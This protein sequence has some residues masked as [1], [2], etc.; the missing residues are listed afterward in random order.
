MVARDEEC[1]GAGDGVTSAYRRRRRLDQG[2]SQ[3]ALTFVLLLR[4]TR[5]GFDP[6]VHDLH[7]AGSL[8][9]DVP[10]VMRRDDAGGCGAPNVS[11]SGPTYPC[12]DMLCGVRDV[13]WFTAPPSEESGGSITN[14]ARHGAG[15]VWSSRDG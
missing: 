2:G 11:R 14:P 12:R 3:V 5:G 15:C 10:L 13:R 9:G 7:G 1:L 6:A 4:H 8:C